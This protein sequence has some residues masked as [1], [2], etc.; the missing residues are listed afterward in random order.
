MVS[1]HVFV[2]MPY[3]IKEGIDFNKVYTDLIKPALDEKEGFEVFRA[4]EELRAGNIRTDMFQELLLAD[5][6][7]VDLSIDNPNV[8]YELGV[9]HALRARGIIQIKSKR[10]YMPFDVYTDRTLTYHIK[11]GLPDPDYIDQDRIRLLAIS[12]ETLSS[13]HERKIS[14]VYHLLRYL[15]EPDW[16]SLKVEDARE[17]W[18]KQAIW[19][20]NVDKARR[21]R[22]PG[23][24]LIFADEAPIRFLRIEAYKSAAKA[25]IKMLEFGLALEP[26]ERALSIDPK[27]IETRQL[28]GII[29]GRLKNFNASKECLRSIIAEEDQ[30]KYNKSE[31]AETYALIGKTEKDSWINA[32]KKGSD[33]TLEE[34]IEYAV[35]NDVLLHEAMETYL[36]GFYLDPSHYYSGINALTLLYLIKYLRERE[37]SRNREEFKDA[38]AEIRR[39]VEGGVRWAIKSELQNETPGKKNYWARVTAG[40]IEILSG[41]ISDIEESYRYAVAAA[42]KDWFALDASRQQLSILRDLGFRPDEVNAAIK[43]FDLA[44]ED[45]PKQWEPRLVFLFSGHMIDAPGRKEPRFPPNKKDVAAQAIAAKLD[46]LGARKDDLALC[47]GACGGDL[48]FAEACLQRGLQLEVRIPFKEP[49]FLSNSVEFADED[50]SSVAQSVWETWRGRFYRVKKHKNTKLLIM[51]EELGET[52]KGVNP[53][54]RNNLWE[55]YS[56]LALGSDKVHFISLW[57]RQEGDGPGG[58]KHMIGEVSKHF[59]QVHILDTNQLFGDLRGV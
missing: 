12:K 51:P 53:Y 49:M 28:K 13:W 9:R 32:W 17:F 58:T 52:P 41:S 31:L 42:E 15:K 39:Y 55:L 30:A 21:N 1:L 47:G 38:Y 19:E 24:I 44:L 59:G 45:A 46:E 22:R 40:D 7:I 43:I 20:R 29:L 27:D 36:K 23:D 16:K 34:T 54:A 6:V 25:L 37:H 26:I 5:L 50:S 10:D 18:N 35:A 4:D 57:N 3:G 11:N 8:W 56:A 14:P 2:A 33:Q 48:L